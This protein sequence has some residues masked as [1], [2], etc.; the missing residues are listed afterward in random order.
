[1]YIDADE[2]E[3]WGAPTHKVW[4]WAR[5]CGDGGKGVE[6]SEGGVGGRRGM[7]MA[8]PGSSRSSTHG[9]DG[10]LGP[11]AALQEQ[12]QRW[13][14]Q[15]GRRRTSGEVEA[16]DGPEVGGVPEGVCLVRVN[17]VELSAEAGGAPSIWRGPSKRESLAGPLFPKRQKGQIAALL[18]HRRP[19]RRLSCSMGC[20]RSASALAL[21]M[22]GA[23][24]RRC[25][26][27]AWPCAV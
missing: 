10:R 2:P 21:L 11:S 15:G 23:C 25:S 9:Y 3:L 12:G 19:S 17:G 16:E 4:P 27:L 1:V 20:F 13:K 22:A 8:A 14:G 7:G 6:G 5:A 24:S 18:E 26:M